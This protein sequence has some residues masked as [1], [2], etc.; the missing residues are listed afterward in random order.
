[1]VS[2]LMSLRWFSTTGGCFVLDFLG[3]NGLAEGVGDGHSTCAFDDY[4]SF[5]WIGID[6]EDASIVFAKLVV[7]P[8]A[9]H[10]FGTCGR[11]VI[12]PCLFFALREG[13]RCV[14]CK[15]FKQSGILPFAAVDI[16]FAA[17]FNNEGDARVGVAL[18]QWGF[19]HCL[20]CLSDWADKR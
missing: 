11:G 12:R 17:F 14:R 8:C 9:K 15:A 10:R 19:G 13:V 5:G 3:Q 2:R 18:H 16:V 7:W 4:I 20:F 1:M 6:L